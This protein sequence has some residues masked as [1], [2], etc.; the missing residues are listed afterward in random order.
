MQIINGKYVEETYFAVNQ[1][2]RKQSQLHPPPKKN[3][4]LFFLFIV[5]GKKPQKVL[6]LGERG[7]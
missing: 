1:P 7:R 3:L 2:K 6:L 5:R 4:C